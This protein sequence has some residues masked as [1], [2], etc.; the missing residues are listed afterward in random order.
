MSGERG[1]YAALLGLRHR[2]PGRPMTIADRA[3]PGAGWRGANPESRKDGR[4]PHRQPPTAPKEGPVSNSTLPPLTVHVPDLP[5]LADRVTAG[6][7]VLDRLRPGWFDQVDPDQLD[8]AMEYDDVLGQLYGHYAL[9]LETLVQA[10]PEPRPWPSVW[11][12]DHGFDLL[13]YDNAGYA[14]LTACWRAEIVGRGG[15][16]ASERRP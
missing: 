13:A 1:L 16:N 4:A 9:G 15:V 8:M 14:E 12:V 3:R 6:A 11:A 5:P 2:S 10:S 7:A